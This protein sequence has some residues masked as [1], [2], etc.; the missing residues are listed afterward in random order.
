M[1]IRNLELGK[2]HINPR[3]TVYLDPEE[4]EERSW[5]SAIRIDDDG[6]RRLLTLRINDARAS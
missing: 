6:R 2:D 4:E 3:L 5:D 1:R